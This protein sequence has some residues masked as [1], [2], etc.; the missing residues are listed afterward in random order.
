MLSILRLR[1]EDVYCVER[2]D[3]YLFNVVSY[4]WEYPW[5]WSLCALPTSKLNLN[6]TD[7]PV[8]QNSVGLVLRCVGSG[9][10]SS[11]RLW[12]Q[13]KRN[14]FSAWFDQQESNIWFC[15]ARCGRVIVTLKNDCFPCVDWKKAKLFCGFLVGLNG[16]AGAGLKG[17][18]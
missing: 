17:W 2:C 10:Y 15:A 12:A 18:R 6:K 13:S 16:A 3:A 5:L 14:H 8:I 11:N 1:R 7:F 9:L 4:M